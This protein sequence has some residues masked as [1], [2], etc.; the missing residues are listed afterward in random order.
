[1]GAIFE[2]LFPIGFLVGSL[3]EVHINSNRHRS[4]SRKTAGIR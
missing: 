4:G 1:L 3:W 2:Y